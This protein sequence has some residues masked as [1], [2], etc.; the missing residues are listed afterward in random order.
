MELKEFCN[1]VQKLFSTN[2]DV[3]VNINDDIDDYYNHQISVRC[4][5]KY[6]K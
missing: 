4:K 3:N 5:I 6:S 2:I 1:L